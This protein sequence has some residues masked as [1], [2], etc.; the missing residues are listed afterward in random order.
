MHSIVNRKCQHL[1]TAI[2]RSEKAKFI[3]LLMLHEETDKD[4]MI[5]DGIFNMYRNLKQQ[6]LSSIDEKRINDF[7]K[8]ILKVFFLFNF[9]LRL[10]ILLVI[11]VTLFF[12]VLPHL[13]ILSDIDKLFC[14][15]S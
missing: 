13:M 10:T 9:S 5:V 8:Q 7:L 3:E 4:A 6:T 14:N 11:L 1:L 15:N 12:I 2:Y